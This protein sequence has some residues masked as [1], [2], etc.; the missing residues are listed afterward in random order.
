MLIGFGDMLTCLMVLPLLLT[1]P[2]TLTNFFY[3]LMS[4]LHL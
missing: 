2:G 4:F 1:L 3:S